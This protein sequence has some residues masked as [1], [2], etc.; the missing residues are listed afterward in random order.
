[1]IDPPSDSNGE[2]GALDSADK[3]EQADSLYKIYRD[4]VFGVVGADVTIGSSGSDTEVDVSNI[5]VKAERQLPTGEIVEDG[6]KKRILAF[7]AA[8]DL[9]V[10]GNV[11]FEND[12]TAEDHALVLGAADH[13]EIEQRE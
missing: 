13:V 1:M 10:K 5:L 9:H 12:N 2:K 4:N 3:K 6:S 11:T 7:A 8:K